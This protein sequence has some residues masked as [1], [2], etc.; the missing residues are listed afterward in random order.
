MKMAISSIQLSCH[1]RLPEASFTDR[2]AVSLLYKQ[3]LLTSHRVSL[4][5]PGLLEFNSRMLSDARCRTFFVVRERGENTEAH[6]VNASALDNVV[7]DETE[8]L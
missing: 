5:T 7:D 6:A 1:L 4:R 8:V 3:P 2:M